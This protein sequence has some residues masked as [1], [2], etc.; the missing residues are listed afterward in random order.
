MSNAGRVEIEVR[1]T[2]HGPEHVYACKWCGGGGKVTFRNWRTGHEVDC[3]DCGGTG[4]LVERDCG[5]SLCMQVVED[6]EAMS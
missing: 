1:R 4:E 3:N 6:L 5:C 2:S